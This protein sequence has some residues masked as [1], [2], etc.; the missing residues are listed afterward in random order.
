MIVLDVLIIVLL[1]G[2]FALSHTLLASLKIK[3]RLAE[4]IGNKIAFYRIF[5]NL[6]SVI[7]FVA[8]YSISPKPDV[9]VYDLQ[10]PYDIS[11]FALQ[12]LSLIGLV[13]SVRPVSLGEFTGISQIE[14]Y[15]KNE[16]VVDDLD[17]RQKLNKTGAFK[18]VRHPIYL[19]SI[20]FLG[21]RPTMSLFFLVM[22]LCVAVYF[23]IGSIYEEKKLVALF[24]D[25][26]VEYQKSTPRIFPLRFRNKK[27]EQ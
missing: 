19:F 21:I 17:E 14:R 8:V 24:G 7:F 22:F 16:Y 4:R 20:L 18:F 2:V 10:S 12:V 1:F 13:W 23:Y 27:R 11:T 26:Y 3:R 25:D 15:L 6:T 5:Y 9:I